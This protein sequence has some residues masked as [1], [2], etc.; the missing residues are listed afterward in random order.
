MKR[1]IALSCTSSRVRREN[2]VCA[3]ALSRTANR[4]MRP[5]AL[6][7]PVQRRPNQPLGDERQHPLR[8]VLRDDRPRAI[9][10]GVRDHEIADEPLHAD[11]EHL[12]LECDV[13][14]QHERCPATAAAV[15]TAT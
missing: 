11:G 9:M 13:G 6:E 3:P 2:S 7:R 5:G 15:R 8:L 4:S 14:R 12:H 1:M 10:T